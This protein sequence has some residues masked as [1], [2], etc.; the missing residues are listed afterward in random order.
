[1]LALLKVKF[2][3]ISVY[4]GCHCVRSKDVSFNYLIYWKQRKMSHQSLVIRQN[5]VNVG[6]VSLFHFRLAL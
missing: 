6:K 4:F 2:L 3:F 5:R 1:M